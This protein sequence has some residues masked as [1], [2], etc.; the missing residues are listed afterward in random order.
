[1]HF[2]NFE[3]ILK[4]LR[5]SLTFRDILLRF[6]AFS[7]V[8]TFSDILGCSGS[9][10]GFSLSFERFLSHSDTFSWLLS[11]SEGFLYVLSNSLKFWVCSEVF[12]GFLIGFELF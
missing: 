12:L 10:R 4:L 6:Y 7:W 11:D 2:E 1:M 9:F 5:R 8:E 3:A